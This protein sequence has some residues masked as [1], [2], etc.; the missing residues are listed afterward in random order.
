M[1]NSKKEVKEIYFEA[2]AQFVEPVKLWRPYG[3]KNIFP[4]GIIPIFSTAC[5]C[6]L[7]GL[8]EGISFFPDSTDSSKCFI[9]T[10][11][12]NKKLAVSKYSALRKDW[13]LTNWNGAV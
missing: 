3:M 11:P 13:N 1:E 12:S 8:E 4:G 10:K 7:D 6:S 5:S 2:E 9:M